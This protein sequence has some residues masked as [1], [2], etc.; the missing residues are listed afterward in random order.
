M[1]REESLPR[2]C[3]ARASSTFPQTRPGF[4]DSI[5]GVERVERNTD[6]QRGTYET[7]RK[8]GSPVS[9]VTILLI[10]ILVLV[11]LYCSGGSSRTWP[12]EGQ[13]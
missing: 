1:V 6:V 10:I 7:R 9:V 11:V 5:A 3:R 4:S 2:G 13:R 12:E 8:G